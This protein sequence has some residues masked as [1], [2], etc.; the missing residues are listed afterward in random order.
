LFVNAICIRHGGKHR[1]DVIVKKETKTVKQLKDR[2][3]FEG[4]IEMHLEACITVDCCTL[5]TSLFEQSNMAK[6]NY[7]MYTTLYML[8]LKGHMLMLYVSV[9]TLRAV[10]SYGYFNYGVLCLLSIK[11]TSSQEG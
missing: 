3:R 9:Y 11:N 2:A 5:L 7:R 1:I 10:L 6:Y 8:W 4:Y